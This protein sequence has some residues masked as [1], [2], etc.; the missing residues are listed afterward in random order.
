[1]DTVPLAA[2]KEIREMA[3]RGG[4]YQF[5]DL[6]NYLDNNEH[7]ILFAFSEIS[8][9]EVSL[10]DIKKK[11]AEHHLHVDDPLK[12]LAHLEEIGLIRGQNSDFHL[13]L[14]LIKYWIN[15]KQFSIL[16]PEIGNNRI[17]DGF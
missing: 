16:F 3:V 2:L 11:L 1:M 14:V 12:A 9:D 8:R 17:G 7:R 10:E 13:H 4:D 6:W 15:K 5:F